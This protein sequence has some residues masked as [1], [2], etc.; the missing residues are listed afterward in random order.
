VT[1]RVRHSLKWIHV[2]SIALTGKT[3]VL[4][5]TSGSLVFVESVAKW[6]SA[7]RVYCKNAM[8]THALVI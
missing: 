6:Y 4:I 3:S 8:S 5:V 2:V 1:N 7:V